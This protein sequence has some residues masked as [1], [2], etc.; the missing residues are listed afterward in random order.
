[1]LII[2][3]DTF[4]LQWVISLQKRC[5]L[6]DISLLRYFI[7]FNREGEV[8]LKNC[9]A[10]EKTTI[11]WTY[12]SKKFF[13]R[14]HA[15]SGIGFL[16]RAKRYCHPCRMLQELEKGWLR[17]WVHLSLVQLNNDWKALLAKTTRKVSNIEVTSFSL[18]LPF[19]K[20]WHWDSPLASH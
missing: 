9:Y 5:M 1:M 4:S 12:H 16:N 10:S 17:W 15:V 7:G 11:I 13:P 3:D 6:N 20:G 18:L 19:S 14:M 8:L 2:F